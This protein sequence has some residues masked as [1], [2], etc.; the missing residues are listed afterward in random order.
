MTP[1][2]IADALGHSKRDGN[3][4]VAICPCHD[5]THPSLALHLG[6]DGRLLW[7]C[8]AGCPQDEIRDALAARGLLNG[9][10]AVTQ[11]K[12]PAFRPVNQAAAVVVPDFVPTD[13]PDMRDTRMGEPVDSWTYHAY[14]DGNFRTV[15]HV[16]RYETPNGKSIRPWSWDGSRWIQRAYPAPRPLFNLGSLYPVRDAVHAR[17]ELPA[18]VVEGEKCAVAACRALPEEYTVVTWSGGAAAV[19]KT[20]W[21]P[22][23]SRRVIIWPDRDASG[24]K[25]AEE[26][27]RLL[28]HAEVL[29]VRGDDD[30]WDVADLVEA[31]G[32]DA[33]RKFIAECPRSQPAASTNARA[34]EAEWRPKL[35]TAA[36][37]LQQ[38]FKPLQW[39][40][41]DILPAG[42]FIL[43]APPK[44]GKSWF[45][46]QITLAVASGADTLGRRVSKGSALYLALEDNDRRLQKRLFKYRA[47]YLAD[48]TALQRAHF[49]TDWKRVNEGGIEALY[50]WVDAHPDARLIVI[51]TLE[52]FR[53]ARNARAD[54]YAEDYAALTALKTLCDT[55]GITVL[56]I[57]HTRKAEADDPFDTISGTQGLSGSADGALV[58]T[59]LRGSE[60]ATLNIVG[61]DIEQDGAFAVRFDRQ[62]C[63]WEMEGPAQHV[64][65]SRERQSVIDVLKREGK[66]MQAKDIAEEMGRQ[67]ATVRGLLRRMM[68]DGYLRQNPDKTYEYL[69]HPQQIEQGEQTKQGQQVNR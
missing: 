40:L 7:H 18:L 67:R 38:E 23:R 65:K 58:L 57:H 63:R 24:R 34:N 8:R 1:D 56:V 32:A 49:T 30:G 21:S 28:P 69:E 52:R 53:P 44:I 4:F 50:A 2:Q 31:E 66:P 33:V 5:D 26:I 22:L 61:R 68:N 39:T 54:K 41:A 36:F 51:D 60:Q 27:R 47:G 13:T 64:A 9:N 37:I 10:A 17:P 15:F 55:R 42:L 19:S 3:G 6:D 20:D 62:T 35:R 45:A 46:M 14:V 48:Q 59:R 25:A 11:P 43:A 16:A 12:R 29:D